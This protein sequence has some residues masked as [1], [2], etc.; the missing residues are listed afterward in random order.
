[1]PLLPGGP[2][3]GW[4]RLLDTARGDAQDLLEFYAAPPVAGGLQRVQARSVV[5]WLAKG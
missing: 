4:R 3:H 1:L 5:M 2:A